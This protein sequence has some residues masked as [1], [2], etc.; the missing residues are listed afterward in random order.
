[1]WDRSDYRAAGGSRELQRMLGLVPRRMAAG[2]E[3]RTG[4]AVPLRGI[5]ERDDT[6]PSRPSRDVAERRTSRARPS[7]NPNSARRPRSKRRSA[8]APAAE[9]AAVPAAEPAAEP[10]TPPKRTAPAAPA[11]APKAQRATP[12]RAQQ[13]PAR[14]ES[15]GLERFPRPSGVKFRPSNK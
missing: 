2:A 5:R 10:A 1:M 15:A 8:K 3:G 4:S 14:P 12:P 13:E 6:A 9:P 7:R 11:S